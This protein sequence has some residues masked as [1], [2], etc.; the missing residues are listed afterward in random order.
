MLGD[1]KRKK[2][3]NFFTKIVAVAIAIS[4]T[5]S[6]MACSSDDDYITVGESQLVGLW[7]L[8]EETGYVS[9]NGQTQSVKL[10]EKGRMRINADYTCNVYEWKSSS[11]QYAE[12]SSL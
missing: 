8:T 12:T 5:I 6:F 3:K 7:E 2:M 9:Y 4:T 1:T 10:D 11:Q